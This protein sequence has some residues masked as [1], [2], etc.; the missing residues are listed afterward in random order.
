MSNKE[1]NLT[2]KLKFRFKLLLN[3][4]GFLIHFNIIGAVKLSDWLIKKINA[5]PE[6]CFSVVQLKGG[7]NKND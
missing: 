4:L 7:D 1:I 3:T 2:I 5:Q 6:R